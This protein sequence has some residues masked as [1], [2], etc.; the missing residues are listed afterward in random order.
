MSSVMYNPT[1]SDESSIRVDPTA[2]SRR[3]SVSTFSTQLSLAKAL[4]ERGTDIPVN[5]NETW[6]W[7]GLSTPNNSPVRTPFG[8][9]IISYGP[10][11]LIQKGAKILRQTFTGESDETDI[12][13]V[14]RISKRELEVS[15]IIGIVSTF[16]LSTIA[17]TALGILLTI[18]F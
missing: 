2:Q 3:N 1:C 7:S 6:S 11:H 18:S 9:Q 15:Q 17:E 4:Q 5:R 8:S 13:L 10:L 12:S 16:N 14:P